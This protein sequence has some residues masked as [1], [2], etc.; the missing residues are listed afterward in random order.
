MPKTVN[1]R[2]QGV[3]TVN[4]SDLDYQYQNMSTPSGID[5]SKNFVAV[6]QNSLAEADNV[7]INDDGVLSS[8]PAIKS[9]TIPYISSDTRIVDLINVNGIIFYHLLKDNKYSVAFEYNESWREHS[10]SSKL[11]IAFMSDMFVFFTNA[12]IFAYTTGGQWKTYGE[13]FHI[14]TTVVNSSDSAE[15]DNLFVDGSIKKLIVTDKTTVIWQEY[16]GDAIRVI[17]DGETYAITFTNGQQVTF[18][19]NINSLTVNNYKISDNGNILAYNEAWEPYYYSADGTLF[20][21]LPP[22]PDGHYDDLGNYLSIAYSYPIISNNGGTIFVLGK[23]DKGTS[24]YRIDTASRVEWK[25]IDSTLHPL[26]RIEYTPSSGDYAYLAIRNTFKFH[27][28]VASSFDTNF[29]R[30]GLKRE[31]TIGCS[32]DDDRCV[33][34][35]LP[36]DKDKDYITCD[37]EMYDYDS[38]SVSTVVD[39]ARYRPAYIHTLHNSGGQIVVHS[40]CVTVDSIITHDMSGTLPLDAKL[41]TDSINNRSALFILYKCDSW[42]NG[43]GWNILFDDNMK[44]FYTLSIAELDNHP[45][46]RLYYSF[47]NIGADERYGSY[48]TNMYRLNNNEIEIRSTQEKSA[49]L[50]CRTKIL[51]IV[52]GEDVLSSNFSID[53]DV[54]THEYNISCTVLSDTTNDIYWHSAGLQS[55]KYLLATEDFSVILTDTYIYLKSYETAYSL[56]HSNV[57][58]LSANW[59]GKILYSINGRLYSNDWSNAIY[60]EITDIGNY[61]L[62]FVNHFKQHVND[63]IAINNKLYFR[64][65]TEDKLLYFSKSN[66]YSFES[67]ITNLVQLSQTTL[68]VFL[69]NAV[70]IIT[71]EGVDSNTGLPLYTCVKSKLQLGCRD[72]DDVLLTYDGSTVL[73]PTLKGLTSLSYEQLMINNEQIYSYL[74]EQLS[75]LYEGFIDGNIKLYQYKSYIIVYSSIKK[76]CYIYDLTNKSWWKW[77]CSKTLSR[78]VYNDESLLLLIDGKMFTLSE[79]GQYLDFG[80]EVINWHFTS[81][82]LHFGAPNNYKHI[83]ALS[84]ESSA[85]VPEDVRYALKCINYRKSKNVNDAEIFEYNINGIRLYVRRCNY[86]KSNAFQFELSS[87]Y[88]ERPKQMKLANI[89]IKYR[90][91]E[92]IR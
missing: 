9:I 55:S 71:Y 32:N 39:A 53:T 87:V 86:Y 28:H 14:P 65:V 67:V 37:I 59:N 18:T 13:I 72:G 3:N 64:T 26:N 38:N 20:Y 84:L 22:L 81:Q 60:I 61:N 7:Y 76:Y 73:L 41:S 34:I 24:I 54:G 45:L 8:R 80:R 85:D 51:S 44:P 89:A 4:Y 52:Y 30:D 36:T 40:Y 66:E 90:I 88:Q 63:F 6:D 77:S 49:S 16:D 42:T 56:L 82:K 74:S 62:L 23:Y 5:E 92:S 47:G 75:N 91:T 17:I 2:V 12:N 10:C 1:R 78:V 68:G 11:T 83:Y 25:C 19:R 46:L 50:S 29:N 35:S 33:F 79:D 15:G 57:R 48:Y 31:G 27:N 21:E 70:Y 43:A 58:P 69:K